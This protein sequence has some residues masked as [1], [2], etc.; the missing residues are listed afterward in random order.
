MPNL[1]ERHPYYQ[2]DWGRMPKEEL[3]LRRLR[4]QAWAM[5]MLKPGDV[6]IVARCGGRARVKMTG[7]DGH[8]ITSASR[9]DIGPL[10]VLRVNGVDAQNPGHA[11]DLTAGVRAWP[12][13]VGGAAS[14]VFQAMDKALA[15]W[16][17]HQVIA[18]LSKGTLPDYMTFKVTD[19]GRPKF[20]SVAPE[21]FFEGPISAASP[22]PLNS[23]TAGPLNSPAA[24]PPSS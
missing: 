3:R 2:M 1:L 21:E 9:V 22:Q 14:E 6:L 15:D 10:D 18:D 24:K 17:Q 8:W 16:V 11:A 20:E 4:A 13:E 19:D 23:S 7:W 5:A 12:V